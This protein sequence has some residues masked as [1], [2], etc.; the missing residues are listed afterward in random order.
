MLIVC[1]GWRVEEGRLDN[2]E[3][4]DLDFQSKYESLTLP[5]EGGGRG[6][7]A[8]ACGGGWRFEKV[9]SLKEN[10]FVCIGTL[11]SVKN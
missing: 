10:K 1:Q 5:T 9:L 3:D 8:E 7:Q 2:I 6:L 4:N 11:M